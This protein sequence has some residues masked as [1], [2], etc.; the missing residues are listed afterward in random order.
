MDA[1][2]LERYTSVSAITIF[3]ALHGWL[4]WLIVLYCISMVTDWLTGTILAIKNKE[5]SSSRAR[6]G[7]WH[8]CGTVFSITVAL[9][10]DFL[11]GLTINNIPG[12]QLSFSYKV[13]IFP[14]VTVWY[15]LSELGSI[16]ENAAAMGAPIPAFLKG[17]LE[18]VQNS[19]ESNEY[20]GK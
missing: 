12:L 2:T 1:E 20:F 3:A 18:K 16:L 15:T 13:M 9:L 7:L 8:K 5:W 11:I 10:T 19:C 14:L 4:G 17:V 6:E